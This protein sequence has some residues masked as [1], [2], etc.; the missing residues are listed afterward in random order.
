VPRDVDRY[1]SISYDVAAAA[2][3]LDYRDTVNT[4]RFAGI[5]VFLL[6][7]GSWASAQ[8]LAPPP[9]NTIESHVGDG[10]A[11]DPQRDRP[12]LLIP[13]YLMQF[14]LHGLDVHSTMRALDA[15][16]REGNPLF[17]DGS[18]KKMIGAKI[19]SSAASVLIAE[20][21]WKKNPLAAVLTMASVN[22]G[23]SA[24]VAHNYRI[25]ATPARR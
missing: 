4:R 14:T 21:L 15:G 7:T 9:T 12:R 20:K 6:G 17:A 18:P 2:P 16:H 3:N 1:E 23:L 5:V 25:A 10:Q 8:S 19:A 11:V 22:A 13:L 24:I